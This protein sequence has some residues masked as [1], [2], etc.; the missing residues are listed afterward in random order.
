MRAKS[1]RLS[2][3]PGEGVV[4]NELF[5]GSRWDL[6]PDLDTTPRR[7]LPKSGRITEEGTSPKSGSAL[8]DMHLGEKS[9]D[10]S[11]DTVE[12]QIVQT[13]WRRGWDSNPAGVLKARN[14][15]ILSAAY[16]AVTAGIARMGYSLGTHC[17]STVEVVA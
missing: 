1:L 4:G 11:F 7:K 5:S 6:K 15:L 16:D 17:P 13:E 14:L 12:N 10:T 3:K 9:P 2:G 8:C